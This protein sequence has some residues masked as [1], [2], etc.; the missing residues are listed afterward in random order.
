MHVRHRC[1]G[2][3]GCADYDGHHADA[4]PA[5]DDENVTYADQ[6]LHDDDADDGVYDDDAGYAYGSGNDV[7]DVDGA[8]DDDTSDHGDDV[9]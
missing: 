6:G 3:D 4:D 9:Q 1:D 5:G 7:Y 8:D 2:G